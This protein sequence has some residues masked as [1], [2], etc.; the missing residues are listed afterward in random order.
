MVESM[1]KKI[2]TKFGKSTLQSIKL[3]L[4]FYVFFY[5]WFLDITGAN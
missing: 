4:N 3:T 2:L 5:M 1:V